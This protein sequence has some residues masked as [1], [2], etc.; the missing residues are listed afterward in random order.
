MILAEELFRSGSAKGAFPLNIKKAQQ[1]ADGLAPFDVL[2]G[3]KVR[4]FFDNIAY[5][6]TSL[7]VTIDRH[8]LAVAS[9][10]LWNDE[11][12]EKVSRVLSNRTRYGFFAEAY[13]VAANESGVDRLTMQA[14]TWITWRRLKGQLSFDELGDWVAANM[15][16]VWNHA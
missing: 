3:N 1:I 12:L 9:G 10:A 4:S 5:P 8:A 11:E 2:G 6:R 16:W 13:C 14:T 15:I 7:E